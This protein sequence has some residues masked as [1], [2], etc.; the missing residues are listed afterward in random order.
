MSR[1]A[2]VDPAAAIGVVSLLLVAAAFAI[3][4]SACEGGLDLY[5]WCGV[6]AIVAMLAVP[7]LLRSGGSLLTRGAVAVGL[8]VCAAVAW[9]G[10]LV[11]A[12]VQILCR[13]F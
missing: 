10:G 12:D 13:L 1:R 5:F 9:I 11:V 8:G 3:A 4:P 7:F 6:A 2:W